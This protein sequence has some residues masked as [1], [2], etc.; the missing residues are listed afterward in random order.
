MSKLHM[1]A[2]QANT[3]EKDGKV[4]LRE[5]EASHEGMIQSWAERIPA[6]EFV[7]VEKHLVDITEADRRYFTSTA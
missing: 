7:A 6:E 2:R 4:E 1:S 3:V 5:Y